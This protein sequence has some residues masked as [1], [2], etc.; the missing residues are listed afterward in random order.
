M[1]RKP[2]NWERYFKAQMKDRETRTLVED[3][4]RSLR[5]GAKIAVLRQRKRLSQTQLAAKTGMS[6]P[7]ISR[8]ETSLGQNL[9]LG[10]LTRIARAMD[11]EVE[12]RFQPRRTRANT[13]RA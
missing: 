7:N 3:E 5:L 11:Y 9:T 6:G 13:G 12:I 8:I 1:K 2:T 4:L 10:T